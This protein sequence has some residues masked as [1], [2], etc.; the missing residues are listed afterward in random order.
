VPKGSVRFTGDFAKLKGWGQRF[1]NVAASGMQIVSLQ[2]AEESLELVR[3]GF[4]TTTD[5]YGKKW[6]PLVIRNGRPLSDTGG[7][8]SSWSVRERTAK[9]FRIE[10]HKKHS[11]FHQKGTGLYGPRKK[12]IEPVHAKALKFK[13]PSG[14]IFAKSVKGSPKRRMVPDRGLP[15]R[16]ARRLKATAVETLEELYRK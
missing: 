1:D 11:I 3:E 7:L 6:A 15:P 5:P 9:R 13:G 4:A 10:S 8:R 2:L 16:W 12:R 14:P